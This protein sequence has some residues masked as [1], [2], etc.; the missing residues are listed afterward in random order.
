ME[1]STDLRQ[2]L[3]LLSFRETRRFLGVGA[4]L[5]WAL[6][7]AYAFALLSM[8]VGQMLV[9]G[10]FQGSSP[11]TV[12]TDTGPRW[13][14]APELI[15]VLPFGVAILPMLPTLA[16]LGVALA[17]GVSGVVGLST[18]RSRI[19]RGPDPS[20]PSAAGSVAASAGPAITG[21]ATL[22]ACCCVSCAG[23][24]GLSVVAIASGADAAALQT[25]DWYVA[26]F[27]LGVV[28]LALVAQERMLRRNPLECPRATSRPRTEA[29]R[30]A[31]R[32]ALLLGGITWSLAMLLEFGTDLPF[33]A[34]AALWYHWIF[35]HQLLA[36]LAICAGLFPEELSDRVRRSARS[37][38][39][40]PFRVVLLVAALSWGLWVP[41]FAVDFGLGGLINELLG[42]GGFPASY[43]ASVPE[44]VVGPALVFHWV[45]QHA[46]LAGFG[47]ALAVF[48]A[49][50]AAALAAPERS[51]P[52]VLSPAPRVPGVGSELAPV[53]P[54]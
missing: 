53:L 5:R 43:G 16:T 31:L 45:F 10:S 42:V 15:L 24:V 30:V 38:R 23:A 26:L 7:F 13:W 49:R 20:G 22:G 46:A 1:G 44:G 35:E 3:S 18:V 48:P 9:L 27:Q 37:L 41:P 17:V 36:G 28:L 34:P 52:P 32:A 12:V 25:A 2:M 47:A 11:I 29:A 21:F 14:D 8:I 19:R 54:G 33:S 51:T 4:R 50:T 39:A 6:G 40:V